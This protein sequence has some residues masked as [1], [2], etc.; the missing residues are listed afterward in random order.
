[1]WCMWALKS[2][3]LMIIRATTSVEKVGNLTEAQCIEGN[4]INNREVKIYEMYIAY[5]IYFYVQHIIL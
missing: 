1:M 2:N 5:S 3:I 4:K